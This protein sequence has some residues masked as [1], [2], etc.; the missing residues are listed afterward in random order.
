MNNKI[1]EKGIQTGEDPSFGL[2][3]GN[4]KRAVMISKSRFLIYFDKIG[5]VCEAPASYG[6]KK[7]LN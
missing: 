7:T 4:C 1:K 5:I 2:N 3:L 6:I